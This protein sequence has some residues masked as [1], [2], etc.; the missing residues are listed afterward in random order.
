MKILKFLIILLWIL[1]SKSYD[2]YCTYLHTPNLSKEANPLV[3]VLGLNWF[4]LLIVIGSLTIYTCYTLS[5]IS[6]K[7][8]K[9]YPLE[10]GYSFSNFIAYMYFG[11]KSSWLSILYRIP[12][13]RNKRFHYTFGN[14]FVRYLVFA[15]IVS[16]VMWLL[17]NNSEY[18]REIHN[19]LVIYGIL[20][21]GTFIILYNYYRTNYNKYQEQ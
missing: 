20:I 15:G 10:K 2:A 9:L 7:P 18:Y 1:F 13:I 16:T 12:P 11:K 8:I 5:L 4:W 19:H 21:S 3:S 6:F 17:I 14:I